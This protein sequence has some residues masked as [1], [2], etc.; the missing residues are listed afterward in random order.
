MLFR[1]L[2]KENFQINCGFSSVILF[3]QEEFLQDFRTH[4]TQIDKCYIDI[5]IVYHLITSLKNSYQLFYNDFIV[6]KKES[7]NQIGLFKNESLSS[8]NKTQVSIFDSDVSFFKHI[9]KI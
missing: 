2:M 9:R 1:F 4:L 5:T 7:K 6:F 3:E 8:L